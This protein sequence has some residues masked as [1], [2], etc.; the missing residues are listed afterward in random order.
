M[1]SVKITETLSCE[2]SSSQDRHTMHDP[3][4]ELSHQRSR[5]AWN[6]GKKLKRHTKSTCYICIDATIHCGCNTF[7]QL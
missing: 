2:V 7:A 3:T 5:I 4:S 1:K 6:Q